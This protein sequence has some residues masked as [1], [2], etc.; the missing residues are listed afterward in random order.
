MNTSD[1]GG[2]TPLH[3]SASVDHFQILKLLC[4]NGAELDTENDTKHTPLH[5]CASKNGLE[6]SRCVV[7]LGGLDAY[8]CVY[9]VSSI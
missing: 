3:I 7:D 9:R 6:V 4:E 5:Y 1:D 8:S 2:W